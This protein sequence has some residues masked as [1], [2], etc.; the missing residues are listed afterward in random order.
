[1]NWH[2]A[3]L[4]GVHR[5]CAETAAV[6]C[7]TSHASAVNTPL[8]WIFKKTRYK[9]L[10]THV[11]SHASVVSLLERAEN[12]AILKQ[13]S[14]KATRN[15]DS[16]SSPWYGKEFSP[17]GSFQCRFSYGVHTAPAYKGTLKI[18]NTGS[19]P[20]VTWD[21]RIYCTHWQEQVALLFRLLCLIQGRPPEFPATTIK[22][23]IFIY[24][25][26]I[27]KKKKKERK[28]KDH[29]LPLHAHTHARTHASTHERTNAHTLSLCYVICL[30]LFFFFF[31]SS[32][33]CFSFQNRSNNIT[34]RSNQN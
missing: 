3:W 30:F 5:T 12:S 8:Q 9:K 33:F 17:S 11:E 19:H 24:F 32:F 2:G 21:S 13:S 18:P 34:A 31:F 20:T 10:V 1:M 4:F 16:S 23:Y 27:I 7:G 26:Y 22:Y 28:K 29:P 6:S 25:L 15:T 14:S